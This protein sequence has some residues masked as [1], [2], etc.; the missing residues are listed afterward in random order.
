M[1]ENGAESG[2]AAKARSAVKRTLSEVSVRRFGDAAILTGVLTSTSPKEN[3]K[4]ATTVV[5]V[6]ST[7]RWKIASA[8]WTPVTPAK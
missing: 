3:E 5:F 4:E 2:P 6:Q 8:Q 1:V 7:G